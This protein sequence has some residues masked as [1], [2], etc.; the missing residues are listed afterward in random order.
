MKQRPALRA[1]N[2]D[3]AIRRPP[4][5][6]CIHHTDRGSQ[7]RAHDYQKLL[8]QHGFKLSMSGKGNRYDNT[9]VERCG[10][11]RTGGVHPLHL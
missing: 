9:A 11:S 3:I 6:G 4:P 10:L 2:M 8:R 5:R 7:Y 1:L